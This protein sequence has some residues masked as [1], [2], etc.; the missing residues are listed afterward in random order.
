[1]VFFCV[2]F[3]F[4]INILILNR[5]YDIIVLMNAKRG[6]PMIKEVF[7]QNKHFKDLNPLVVGYEQC[8]P[9]YS[10]GPEIRHNYWIQYVIS[11]CC[12]FE[13]E[14]KKYN[15]KSNQ[16]FII[17]PSKKVFFRADDKTPWAYT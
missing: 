11:G 7:F 15:L 9:G 3:T 6:A 10:C 2:F 13:L 14:S 5:L 12:V 17:P 16:A 4:R 1:M 8:S